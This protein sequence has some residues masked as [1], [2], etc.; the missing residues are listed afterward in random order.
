MREYGDKQSRLGAL[1]FG[2]SGVLFA[3]F[4][5]VRPYYLDLARDP[6][7]GVQVI[8]SPAWMV[9]HVLLILALSLLPF[10]LLTTFAVL[11][12]TGAERRALVGMVLGIA[13]GC[14]F[15]PVAGVEAFALP[16]IAHLY[17]QGQIGTLDAIETARSGLRATIFL[18]GLVFLGLGGVFTALAAW[19]S[20]RLPRWAAITFALGLVFFMPL[21]PQPVRMVD[22][23][24]IGIGALGLSRALWRGSSDLGVAGDHPVQGEA[25]LGVQ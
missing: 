1:A 13:G 11:A 17:L 22:G 14:L 9:S 24:L 8:S 10:G 20:D 4:P 23:A 6:A 21:L 5:I 3:A 15:L 12:P 16:A 2:I 7:N 19:R 18:P 25:A